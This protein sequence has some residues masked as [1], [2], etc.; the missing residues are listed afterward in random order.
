MK[1]R[2]YL[3]GMNGVREN[4]GDKG[5]VTW[6]GSHRGEVRKLGRARSG[7]DL[8]VGFG[9]YFEYVEKS[10]KDYELKG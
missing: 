4:Q 1:A 7:G 3:E 10:L 6:G 8:Q 9:F 5:R 2:S